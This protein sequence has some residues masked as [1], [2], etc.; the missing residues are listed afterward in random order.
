M[1]L[2]TS[3]AQELIEII[4]NREWLGVPVCRGICTLDFSHNSRRQHSSLIQPPR[5]PCFFFFFAN[6]IKSYHMKGGLRRG[7]ES[8]ICSCSNTNIKQTNVSCHNKAQILLMPLAHIHALFFFP[9]DTWVVGRGREMR[10]SG[11]LYIHIK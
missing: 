6:S 1:G 8:P 10:V 3:K 11:G 5:I 9:N 4:E 2:R 7:G